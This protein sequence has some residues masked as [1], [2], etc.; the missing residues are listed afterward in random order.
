MTG[1][2]QRQESALCKTGHNVIGR[3]TA[4]LLDRLSVGPARHSPARSRARTPAECPPSRHH[5]DPEP[6][7]FLA[8]RRH[9]VHPLRREHVFHELSAE[10]RPH[11]VRR[12][13]VELAAEVVLLAEPT[14]SFARST[15]RAKSPSQSSCCPRGSLGPSSWSPQC[16]SSLPCRGSVI[17]RIKRDDPACPCTR[18]MDRSHGEQLPTNR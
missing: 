1:N 2:L 15:T 3:V 14:T 11:S 7:R 6:D 8:E 9:A 13:R 17:S 18:N 4:P 16:Q 10:E 12:I 5:V